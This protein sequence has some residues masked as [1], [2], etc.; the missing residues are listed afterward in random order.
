MTVQEFLKQSEKKELLRL[1]TAGSVDDGKS[2]MIGRLLHD[3]KL[4]YEDHL[5]ALKRD[6]LKK[7]SVKD[8]FD[9]AL[10]LDGLKAE[11]E[12]NITIDVAYRYFS[13]PRRKFIIAD[14]PGHEQYT[15]NMATGASTSDLAIILLDA[16]KGIL[17]QSKR[18][19][20]IMSLLNIRHIVVA[21][22]KMDL[23]DY[24]E[25]VFEQI[26]K[27]Y[28]DFTAKLDLHDFHFIP[29]SA[30]HG[31]NVVEPGTA[32]PWYS[33]KPLLNYLETVHI[34]GD[35]NL[36]D[37]RFPVQYVLRPDM[38]FRGYC[39]TVVSGTI[40]KGE[41][42]MVLPSG[43]LSR[44][45]S[46]TTYDG[47]IDE[48]FTPM[49]VTITLE[50]ELDISRGNMLI[51]VHNLPN[52]SN[53]FEAMLVWMND[54]P[55]ETDKEYIIKHTTNMVQGKV[56]EIRYKVDVNTLHRENAEK[57]ALNE[58]GRAV[59]TL[60]RPLLFDNYSR[61]RATGSFIIIDRLSNATAG[62]GMIID[63]R[64][65]ELMI[66]R[67]KATT[68][69]SSNIHPH[70]SSIS[71]D[72]RLERLNQRPVT[73][74]FT[75]LP[76]SGKSTI[77]YALEKRLFDM[78]YTIHVIDGENMR[79]TISSDLAFTADERSENVRRAAGVAKLCNNLG[80]I[81][82]AAF[83]SPFEEDRA[84]IRKNIGSERF[85]E[86]YLNTPLEVCEER[87]TDGLYERARTGEIEYFTGISSPYE[88][89]E[90]PD[91]TLPAHEISVEDAVDKIIE[92][93]RKK[94]IIV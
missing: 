73:V 80:L 10:L 44:V 30:L 14:T 87:D 24:S 46:I 84:N 81:T 61:N 53:R 29:M 22:N 49:S 48:A 60:N 90:D 38:N 71:L 92:L 83:V 35:R 94:K 57:L 9:Y 76:K 42:V 2:T 27:D 3:S 54:E 63:R 72:K 33:G 56:T 45:K 85:V 17:P 11:R 15:R 68:P 64:P 51:H 18:H 19:S 28:S 26:K 8:D 82:I 69:R 43:R 79:L 47:D 21:V 23:V 70:K 32:M 37:L 20:F 4:I 36:V 88:P 13:T 25:E 1:S 89:P 66:S 91:L 7:G 12:Q 65:N 52:V 55:L 6:T 39:G 78:G 62:A 74:W 77:A 5:A 34:T 16:S 93:L 59:F 40:R 58:I 67:K 31:D 86:I 75:G 50:D 41:K